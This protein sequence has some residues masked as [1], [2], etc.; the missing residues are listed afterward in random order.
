M[1]II[2]MEQENFFQVETIFMKCGHSA[3]A[4]C[5]DKPC[6]AICSCFEVAIHKPNL[7]GRK[8]Q[9]CDCEKIV[10][11]SINLPFFEYR[12]KHPFDKFYCGCKGWD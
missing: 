12:P 6:C 9:C 11:S 5:N 2:L 10:E 7:L 8:A 3:N 1:G 4:V